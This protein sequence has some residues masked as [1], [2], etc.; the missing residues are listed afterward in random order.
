MTGIQD[1]DELIAWY[2]GW[3]RW[4][5]HCR[6]FKCASVDTTGHIEFWGLI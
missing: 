1:V 2:A 3:G 5:A 4:S 6:K